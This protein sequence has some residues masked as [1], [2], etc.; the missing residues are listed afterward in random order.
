MGD[1]IAQRWLT[2]KWEQLRGERVL[3]IDLNNPD[4]EIL[5]KIAHGGKAITSDPRKISVTYRVDT[6]TLPL[7]YREEWEYYFGDSTWGY[8]KVRGEYV[9]EPQ[10]SNTTEVD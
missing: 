10:T 5:R 1:P 3:V 8:I 7:E 9:Q 6:L 2:P 4:Q